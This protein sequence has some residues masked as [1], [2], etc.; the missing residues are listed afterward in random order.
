M[1]ELSYPITPILPEGPGIHINDTARFNNFLLTKL[2][3]QLRRFGEPGKDLLPVLPGAAARVQMKI[4]T[5]DDLDTNGDRLYGQVIVTAATSTAAAIYDSI[6]TDQS[7]QQFQR[8]ERISDKEQEQWYKDRKALV[9]YLIVELSPDSKTTLE[10][11]PAWEIAVYDN[12]YKTMFQLITDTHRFG[13]SQAKNSYCQEFARSRQGALSLEGYVADLRGQYQLFMSAFEDPLHPGYVKGDDLLKS[14]FSTGIN[15]AL[16][17]LPLQQLNETKPNCTALEAQSAIQ[18]WTRDYAPSSSLAVGRV[19]TSMVAE[20]NVLPSSVALVAPVTKGKGE[21]RRGSLGVWVPANKGCEHCF[22]NGY[23]QPRHV[24]STCPFLAVTMKNRADRA[25]EAA[26]AK[27]LVAPVVSGV[28]PLAA[29]SPGLDGHAYLAAIQ[30]AVAENQAA[31]DRAAAVAGALLATAHMRTYVG[32]C[33]PALL[34]SEADYMQRVLLVA[35][36]GSAPVSEPLWLPPAVPVVP[37]LDV[38][39]SPL[40]D[41]VLPH[42]TSHTVAQTT[43][44]STFALESEPSWLLPSVGVADAWVSSVELAAVAMVGYTHLEYSPLLVTYFVSLLERRFKLWESLRLF[45]SPFHSVVLPLEVPLVTVRPS[46]ARLARVPLVTACPAF[47]DDKD[48]T[49]VVR[50]SCAPTQTSVLASVDYTGDD[51]HSGGDAWLS[52]DGALLDDIDDFSDAIR[53]SLSPSDGDYSFMASPCCRP[54]RASVRRRRS[55]SRLAADQ[56]AWADFMVGYVPSTSVSAIPPRASRV[57][58]SFRRRARRSLLALSRMVTRPRT[59]DRFHCMVERSRVMHAY[60]YLIHRSRSS[61]PVLL[62]DRRLL[63]ASLVPLLYMLVSEIWWVPPPVVV[64]VSGPGWV[65]HAGSGSADAPIVAAVDTLSP[66]YDI[67]SGSSMTNGCD[68]LISPPWAS[69]SA[70]NLRGSM[71]QSLVTVH[72]DGY[73]RSLVA[74]AAVQWVYDNASSISIT[75][76]FSEL[77]HV[78]LLPEASPLGGIGAGS[79]AITHRG[80]L[81]FLPLH[82]S[83]CYYS[84]GATASLVSLGHLQGHGCGWFFRGGTHSVLIDSGGHILDV[85]SLQSN[86]LTFVSLSRYRCGRGVLSDPALLRIAADC[87]SPGVPRSVSLT[88]P[89]HSDFSA[90]DDEALGAMAACLQWVSPIQLDSRDF[91]CGAPSPLHSAP[92]CVAFLVHLTKE[93]RERCDRVELVHY[94]THAGDAALCRALDGGAYSWASISAA[95]VRLNRTWRGPCPACLQGK[96]RGKSM[97]SSVSQPASAVGEQLVLDTQELTDKSLGGNL[98]YLDSIDEYS[99]DVQITPAKFLK[100]VDLF[101]ASMSLVHTRYNAHGH[102]ICRILSDPLPAMAPV[103]AMVG[104]FGILLTF[105]TPGQ[106]AQRVERSIQNMQGR[107]CSMIAALP[108]ILPKSCNIFAYAW[109]ADTSNALPTA[110]HDVAV[111]ADVLVTGTRRRPH[112]KFPHLLFG[113]TCMVPEFL[114]KRQQEAAALGVPLKDVSRTELGVCMGYCRTDPTSYE[115]LLANDIVV[116]RSVISIFNTTPFGWTP[117]PILAATLRRSL[118]DPVDAKPDDRPIQSSVQPSLPADLASVRAVEAIVASQQ[119]AG[120]FPGFPMFQAPV[121]D[122]PDVSIGAPIS[123]VVRVSADEVVSPAPVPAAVVPPLPSPPST[124]APPAALSPS[125]SPSPV[126]ELRRSARGLVPRVIKSMYSSAYT[127]NE[128]AYLAATFECQRLDE[129][130]HDEAVD[131][132]SADDAVALFSATD[133]ASLVAPLPSSSCQP[134]PSMKG[135]EEPLSKALRSRGADRLVA[136]TLVEVNKQQEFGALGKIPLERSQLPR[137]ALTV[138][139]HCLYKVKADGRDTCRIAAQGDRLPPKPT[140]ETYASVVSDGAKFA[141]IALMQAYCASRKETLYVTDADVVG[142]FLHIKLDSKVPMY[143]RLPPHLPHPL[144]GKYLQIHHAIY[145]LQESNRLFSLEMTRV[146]VSCAGYRAGQAEPQQFVRVAPAGLKS[147]GNVT[148]DDVLILSNSTRLRDI[149]LAALSVRFGPLTVNLESRMH[150]GIEMTRLSDDGI[151]LT[152]D[153]AIARAASVVGVSLMPPIAVPADLEFFQTAFD[154]EEAVVVD[155]AIYSSLTGKLVQF[156]KTRSDVRLLV[157]Y[158]CSFNQVPQEG[159]FR[160]AI[161]VLRYLASTPGFGPVFRASDVELVVF[162][163]AAFGVF[164]NGYSSTG[165]MFCVGRRNAPFHVV[166]R[167]QADVATCPM[168]AEYYSASMA[169]RSIVFF[170]QVFEDL[171]WPVVYPI[172]FYIDNRTCIKLVEAPQVSVKSRHILVQ[173]HYIREFQERKIIR[174]EHV[175][176]CDMRA[177]LLTKVLPKQQFLKARDQVFNRG[178]SV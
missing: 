16:Y 44:D 55:L 3:G 124:P 108:F 153:G 4:P 155:S 91:P 8:A 154:A 173:Y 116:P 68:A 50:R 14:V 24:K 10:T 146:I 151:L 13:N 135:K 77:T 35:G 176:A 11:Y 66:G 84:A 6:L 115:F 49:V 98:C 139:A 45:L 152:Q 170:R 40:V 162:T 175:Y 57:S 137:N 114:P 80:L 63:V 100:A 105:T 149:L 125:P 88:A 129:V 121:V 70:F 132:F 12:D 69:A 47:S 160:R 110:T 30:A 32:G 27:T 36:D 22:N 148:V 26:K 21:S 96:Y 29:V 164:R 126:P 59:V 102:K 81:K 62:L 74:P 133:L 51:L 85:P 103:V 106:H 156:L 143:L 134:I 131:L 31:S 174:V 75:P 37:S 178:E 159:H 93:Q 95:D 107:R 39:D 5:M 72:E 128:Y 136:S 9:H 7:Y 163:D 34:A 147:I 23:N 15:Q 18:K 71:L 87:M 89:L 67:L 123:P 19:S 142:G 177:D 78:E 171:G 130:T 118:S 99:S 46:L 97:P 28:I 157:S 56:S 92:S 82:L 43:W 33:D 25:A 161:H 86:N 111:C 20:V 83:L 117:K 76:Y 113:A 119:E 17:S 79:I 141:S 64:A 52:D 48:W 172:A 120:P 167:A 158:L 1:S 122:S 165:Q 41:S 60:S 53:L 127:L 2:N 101:A 166:A 109:V 73:I 94:M 145:G 58:A 54:S 138:D 65:L 42:L 150:T 104:A 61:T 144:A 140:K 169:C 168:T 90:L 38:S 112:Y